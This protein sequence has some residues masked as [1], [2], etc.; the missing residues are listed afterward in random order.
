MLSMLASDMRF[1]STC[2]LSRKHDTWGETNRPVFRPPN[3]RDRAILNATDPCSDLP[4]ERQ[5]KEKGVVVVVVGVTVV[6]VVTGG[7]RTDI[8]G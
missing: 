6:V 5:S 7:T 3:W 1:P 4:T 2:I 8:S